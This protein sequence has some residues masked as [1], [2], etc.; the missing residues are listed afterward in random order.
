M[1]NRYRELYEQQPQLDVIRYRFENR[2]QEKYK[3]RFPL[4]LLIK[5]NPDPYQVKNYKVTFNPLK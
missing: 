2:E 4:N 1:C 5:Q 3:N